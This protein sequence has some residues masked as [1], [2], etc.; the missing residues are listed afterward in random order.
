MS[1]IKLF[2]TN[3]GKYSRS[4]SIIGVG[5]IPFRHTLDTPE[6]NGI[7]EPELFAWGA[8]EAM[9]DAGIE[10]KDIDAFIHGQVMSLTHSKTMCPNVFAA[11]WIGKVIDV[12]HSYLLQLLSSEGERNG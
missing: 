3:P 2:Q 11:D 1:V 8:L 6:L 10:G 5:A 9:K 4:V 12:H 7:T